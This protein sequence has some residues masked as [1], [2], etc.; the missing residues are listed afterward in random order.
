MEFW[1]KK[2]IL[3]WNGFSSTRKLE[4]L[5][6]VYNKKTKRTQKERNE[7]IEKEKEKSMELNW[8]LNTKNNFFFLP[9]EHHREQKENMPLN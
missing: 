6:S 1:E 4:L 3:D 5:K 8:N 9:A 7:I 2:E